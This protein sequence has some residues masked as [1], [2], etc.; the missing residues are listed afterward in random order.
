[1]SQLWKTKLTYL[2]I[3]N[4]EFRATDIHDLPFL[5]RWLLTGEILKW[6]PM[7][8][9]KEVDDSIRIWSGYAK[10]GAA[11]TVECEGVIC[12]MANLYVQPFKRFA[13][14]ALF[15]IV[16]DEKYR[17]KGIGRRLLEELEKMAKEKFGIEILH[18]EVYDGNPA[19]YLYEKMGFKQYGKQEKFIKEEGR[20]NAKIMMEKRLGRS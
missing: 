6:F 7:C 10:I 12:G 9:E 15:S 19:Q 8:N 4:L 5:K 16:V 2:F 20:Y 3:V 14:Q 1:M 17:G 18:L 11:I 13:H